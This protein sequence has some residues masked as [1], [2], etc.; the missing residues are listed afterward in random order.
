[1]KKVMDTEL[2][3]DNEGV[4]IGSWKSFYKGEDTG[5]SDTLKHEVPDSSFLATWTANTEEQIIQHYYKK[6]GDSSGKDLEKISPKI[7]TVLKRVYKVPF[8]EVKMKEYLDKYITDLFIAE[9]KTEAKKN[10][11]KPVPKI[12]GDLKSKKYEYIPNCVAL[13]NDKAD[14]CNT[15]NCQNLIFSSDTSYYLACKC[16]E[17]TAET[18]P[19]LRPFKGKEQ[20]MYEV[21]KEQMGDEL[22]AKKFVLLTRA[23][24]SYEEE[25]PK[26][27]KKTVVN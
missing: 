8:E 1:M 10:I 13:P 5:T 7:Y 21:F 17:E 3:K 2:L 22:K 25:K 11:S 14:L 6:Y 26:K 15:L 20:L 27:V 9:N 12:T 24:E 23:L 19:L 16:K 4:S 18:C